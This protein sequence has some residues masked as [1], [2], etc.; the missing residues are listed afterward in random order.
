LANHGGEW[1]WPGGHVQAGETLE[2]GAIREAHEETGYR[3]DPERLTKI[4]HGLIEEID[5]T[6]YICPVEAK[7]EPN[8][9][10][11]EDGH[12][13]HD[14]WVWADP[15]DPPEPLH[16]GVKEAI[17][18]E[19]LDQIA[20]ARAKPGV[21]AAE[22]AGTKPEHVIEIGVNGEFASAF[23]VW[24]ATV[25]M[26]AATGHS[27]DLEA[28]REGGEG[29]RVGVDGDGADR[30]LNVRFDGHL[31]KPD[32]S[33][34]EYVDG[35]YAAH[36]VKKTDE[37][38]EDASTAEAKWD[39]LD[40]RPDDLMALDRQSVRSYDVDGRLHVAMTPI[41]RAMICPYLGKEIPEWESLGLEGERTYQLLRDPDEIAKAAASANG[42][43][44]LEVHLATNAEDHPREAVVGAT[45]NDATWEPPFLMQSLTIW[46]A[47][48]IDEIEDE[49]KRQLSASYRY[50]ADMTPC[51]FEGES[52]D[53]VM[54]DLIFNHVA[55][56]ELGRCGPSVA[57]ADAFTDDLKW[58][59]L[60]EAI[61]GLAA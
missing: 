33:P 47:E 27:F 13:E 8:I 23:A 3:A 56:V 6:C 21:E 26:V 61:R 59:L 22:D 42:I 9:T 4:G 5:W 31:V 14:D 41:T 11:D 35:A 48:A 58:S 34:R 15:R 53:G 37:A 17:T 43:P 52:A 57:V 19:M 1:D 46:D 55:L 36:K 12:R 50:R 51:T 45:G 49:T 24:L 10:R 29:F 16:P 25:G 20:R 2:E 44:V 7:F 40:W 30:I 60:E 18:D 28:D 32:K 38:A 39:T 54:R